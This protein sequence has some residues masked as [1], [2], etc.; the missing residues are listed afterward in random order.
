MQ[1]IEAYADRA[2]DLRAYYEQVL[3]RLAEDQLIDLESISDWVRSAMQA[4]T[5]EQAAAE[6]EPTS[7]QPAASP[8][9]DTLVVEG[10]DA[11]TPNVP[12][13]AV[14]APEDLALSGALERTFSSRDLQF[15]A[16]RG[17]FR[18]SRHPVGRRIGLEGEGLPAVWTRHALERQGFEVS[19]QLEG[20]RVRVVE[21]EGSYLW[22]WSFGER[23]GREATIESLLLR[24][25]D[26]PATPPEAAS[27]SS[28]Q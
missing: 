15:D 9:L 19:A 11:I 6:D 14:G 22:E 1:A 13:P 18:F 28:R 26:R 2:K 23:E 27:T 8:L 5:R 4:A 25:S 12:P 17:E 21:V 3:D 20:D 16:E 10:S 24:L 7:A